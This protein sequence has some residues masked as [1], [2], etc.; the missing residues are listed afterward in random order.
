MNAIEKRLGLTSMELRRLV[1]RMP[2]ILGMG[3]NS[4]GSSQS[5]LDKRIDFFLNEGTSTL[6]FLH[7]YSICLITY[8]LILKVRMSP[9]ELKK[10]IL[11]QPALLQYSVENSLRPKLKFLLN[12]IEVPIDAISRVI[13]FAPSIM[14]LSLDSNLRPTVSLLKRRCDFSSRQVGL[15]IANS[16][17]ILTLS[18]KKKINP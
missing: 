5:A 8:P 7:L 15:L 14:G 10:A 3:I 2:S 11:K 16:P 18:L 1:L 17:I 4:K 12:D 6:D 9:V 13:K